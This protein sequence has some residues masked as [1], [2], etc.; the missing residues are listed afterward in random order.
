VL[1]T[2]VDAFERDLTPWI[3]QDAC[4]SHA[5]PEPH[6]AG[7]L[8]ARRF[9]GRSQIISAAG[10]PGDACSENLCESLTR[11]FG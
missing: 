6:N 8:V 4:A 10:L 11:P 3:V 5:G 7:L 2:A 1:K 9:I